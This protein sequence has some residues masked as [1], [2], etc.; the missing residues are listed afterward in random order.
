MVPHLDLVSIGEHFY[1]LLI[2]LNC[3]GSL[4]SSGCNALTCVDGV[5]GDP[6][7]RCAIDSSFSN[8]D[9]NVFANVEYWIMVL[10]ERKQM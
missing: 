8:L 2:H 9:I 3:N 6:D 4:F 10:F 1:Y 7:N 5:E